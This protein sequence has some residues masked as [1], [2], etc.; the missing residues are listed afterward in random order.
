MNEWMNEIFYLWMMTAH[1]SGMNER[2]ICISQHLIKIDLVSH[3]NQNIN[4]HNFM[5]KLIIKW[6]KKSLLIIWWMNHS[7]NVFIYFVDFLDF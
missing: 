7:E 4:L 5:N 3:F 6:K 2:I 1:R